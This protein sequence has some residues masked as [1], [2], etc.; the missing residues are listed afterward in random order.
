VVRTGLP[1]GMTVSVRVRAGRMAERA[2]AGRQIERGEALQ[3]E[4]IVLAQEI[5][6]GAQRRPV[7]DVQP[8]WVAQRFIKPGDALSA[9]AVQAPLAVL[10]GRSVDLLWTRGSVGIRVPG[11]AAGSAAVGGRVSVRT[12]T[13]ERLSGVVVAPGVV[14]VTSGEGK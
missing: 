13:G 5:V 7:S 10:S 14:N 12:Q 2:V 8:G 3:P 6:W 9:P 4:D 11:T 1:S